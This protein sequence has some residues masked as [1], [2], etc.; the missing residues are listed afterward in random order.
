MKIGWFI[1][2]TS[3]DFDNVSASVWIRC[4]QLIPYLEASGIKNAIGDENC[5]V[6]VFVRR[7][8]NEAYSIARRLHR[9]GKP[10][11]FDL[12][13]N[14]FER[15]DATYMKNVV[16]QQHIDDCLRM[17]ELATCVTCSSAFIA[18]KSARHHDNVSYI[19]D[20]IDLRHFT[21]RK[22]PSDFDRERLRALWCGTSSKSVD[23]KP[24]LPLL[25]KH[26]LDLTIVSNARPKLGKRSWF[27][28]GYPLTFHR[29]SHG[30]P[31][32]LLQ[33]DIFIGHRKLETTYDNGHSFFKIGLPLSQ[34]VPALAS[35]VPSYFELLKDGL[36]GEICDNLKEFD[37]TLAKIVSDR[38]RLKQWSANGM[39]M[40]ADYSTERIAE[41]YVRLFTGLTKAQPAR[42][43]GAHRT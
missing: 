6:G 12:V 19:P 30:R 21:G 5:D 20:S 4:L 13:A 24:I 39:E 38:S 10:I 22:S 16:T 17:V 31:D 3:T 26:G 23:L 7:Q 40:M 11:I 37:E 14:Y 36:C 41:T 43:L 35:P 28:R 9:Q 1:P 2:G 42:L 34:G 15:S 8:D 25:D 18:D 33:G 29:W 27:S 32:H